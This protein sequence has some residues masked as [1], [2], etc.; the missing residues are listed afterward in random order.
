MTENTI[1][2]NFDIYLKKYI[3]QKINCLIVG[4]DT[5]D[6]SCWLLNNL[7]TNIF[8]R[9]FSLENWIDPILEQQFDTNIES[10]NKID[11]HVKLNMNLTKGL[12]RLEK[13]KYV[14]FDIIIINT[15]EEDKDIISNS[16]IAWNLLNEDGIMIFDNFRESYTEDE[17]FIPKISLNSFIIMYKEYY[18]LLTSKYQFIIEKKSNILSKDKEQQIINIINNYNFEQLYIKLNHKIDEELE[19]RL[20]NLELDNTMNNLNKMTKILYFHS[21]YV[22]TNNKKIQT[23]TY[24]HNKI[25]LYIKEY[26]IRK[27]NI[28][29]YPY[30]IFYK[31]LI[32]YKNFKHIYVDSNTLNEDL[33]NLIFKDVN[34]NHKFYISFN[35]IELIDK[36]YIKNIKHIKKYD[37]IYFNNNKDFFNINYYIYIIGLSINIQEKNGTFLLQIPVIFNIN[38]IYEIIYLLQRYYNKITIINR[39]PKYIGMYILIKCKYFKNITEKQLLQLNN[40]ILE[41]YKNNKEFN[42][43]LNIKSN[44]IKS[45]VEDKLFTYIKNLNSDVN[46]H[47]IIIKNISNI[48]I[49]NLYICRL[50]FLY[51]INSN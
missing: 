20:A 37:L 17:E 22:I 35:N 36:V 46:N 51:L 43:I 49:Y 11:Y 41:L 13:I 27:S 48:I 21:K 42:S 25:K 26:N 44:Y 12:V 15:K 32:K 16:I 19:F 29:L 45:D 18:K 39:P 2:K 50:I 6:Y 40:F 34:F 28:L 5:G 14:I 30:I 1:Y 24:L 3:G 38:I 8:S 4:A 47:K 33:F 23:E 31:I 7:C 10:T 9:V